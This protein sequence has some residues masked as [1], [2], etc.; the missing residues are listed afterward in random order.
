MRTILAITT[1][2]AMLWAGFY[3]DSFVPEIKKQWWCFPYV[4][5]AMAYLVVPLLIFLKEVNR[6]MDEPMKIMMDDLAKGRR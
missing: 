3:W 4:I 1:S 6:L 5:T 2:L